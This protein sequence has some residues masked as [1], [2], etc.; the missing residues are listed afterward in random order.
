MSEHDVDLARNLEATA[1]LR[2]LVARLDAADL[3]RPIEGGWTVAFA[4]AHVAF[5]DARQDSALRI[6]ASGDELPTEDMG[7]NAALEAIAGLFDPRAAAAEA[8][9]AAE[10]LDA[11]VAGLAAEQIAA[12]RDANEEYPFRRWPHREEHIGQ[13]EDALL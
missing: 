3:A 12:L 5:W 1:S 10:R 11:T 13:I 6:Y 8:V 2:E 9:A 4:L 7:V